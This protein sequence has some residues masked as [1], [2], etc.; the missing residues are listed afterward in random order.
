[1]FC[2]CAHRRPMC[3]S[4]GCEPLAAVVTVL[5]PYAK[6]DGVWRIT[7]KF[8]CPEHYRDYHNA[9][10]APIRGLDPPANADDGWRGSIIEVARHGIIAAAFDARQPASQ[11]PIA[12]KRHP[13]PVKFAT[14]LEQLTRR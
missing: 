13:L 11:I 1:M 8:M 3:Q 7:A 9:L 2:E 10:H 14:R 12:R 5:A 4:R 6:R